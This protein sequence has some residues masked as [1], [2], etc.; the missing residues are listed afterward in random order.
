MTPLLEPLLAAPLP[1]SPL[2]PPPYCFFVLHEQ[3][4]YLVAV[5][6]RARKCVCVCVCVC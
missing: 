2:S 3:G 4:K 1:L 6:C 5:V